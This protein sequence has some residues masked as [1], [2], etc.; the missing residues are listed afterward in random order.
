MVENSR[1][2]NAHGDSDFVQCMCYKA[3]LQLHV[4]VP[5]MNKCNVDGATEKFPRF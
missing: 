3:A 1:R 5:K 2:W 4:H